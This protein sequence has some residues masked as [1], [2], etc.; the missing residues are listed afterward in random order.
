MALPGFFS[1]GEPLGRFIKYFQI[2][3]YYRKK[4]GDKIIKPGISYSKSYHAVFISVKDD[5]LLIECH[6]YKLRD[7][8]RTAS[9]QKFEIACKI[10]IS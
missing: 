8:N 3:K 5:I 10:F 6:I 4:D 1:E 2:K 9:T 7:M